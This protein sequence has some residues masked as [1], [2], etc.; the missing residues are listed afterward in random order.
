[1]AT[2]NLIDR[3]FAIFS[4]MY[5]WLPKET[6]DGLRAVSLQ[7]ASENEFSMKVGPENYHR[8]ARDIRVISETL[9]ILDLEGDL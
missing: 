4:R 8:W 5:D 1:M 3:T 9:E 7:E 2:T 6:V